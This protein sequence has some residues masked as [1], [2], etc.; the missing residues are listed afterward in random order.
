MRRPEAMRSGTDRLYQLIMHE[1]T[2][3]YASI[4]ECELTSFNFEELFKASVSPA[5][6]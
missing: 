1:C 5:G 6:C 3:T 2:R 4:S